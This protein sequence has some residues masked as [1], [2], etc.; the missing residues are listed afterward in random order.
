M[1]WRYRQELA[2]EEDWRYLVLTL[3]KVLAVPMFLHGLY[4]TALTKDMPMLALATAV[5]SFGLL[6]LQIELVRGRERT[7]YA[8]L[9]QRRRRTALA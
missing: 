4:D 3:L 8:E 5:A 7:F 9:N 1:I 2:D 6:T